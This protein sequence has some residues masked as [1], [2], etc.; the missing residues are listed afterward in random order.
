[1]P[2]YEVVIEKHQELPNVETILP[3]CSDLDSA[4][5]DFYSK[6]TVT[7]LPGESHLF[8]TDVK[9]CLDPGTFLMLMVR[10]SIGLKYNLRMSNTV[11]IIDQSYYNNPG[12]DGNIGISLVNTGK[13][14]VTIEKG[15]RIAQ[16]I[17]LPFIA[18]EG[19]K[20]LKAKREG[21]YGSSG[22]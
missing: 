8:W 17:V 10:S 12:N 9:A 21:G 6:E 1:M 5:D 20:P 3:T 4:G 2:K 22:K 13:V 14:H 11:G 7:I 15:M 16:G 19:R 18:M